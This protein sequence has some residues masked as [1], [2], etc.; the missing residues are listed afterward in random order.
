M[1]DI[2]SEPEVDKELI[3]EDSSKPEHVS[4]VSKAY[5]Q[6]RELIIDGR[7]APGTRIVEVD[8]ATRLGVSRTP[9]RDALRLLQQEGFVAA[10][11]P[12]GIKARLIVAPLTK[13]DAEEVYGIVGR[14]E[15]W[16]ARLSAQLPPA[17]RSE[18]AQKLRQLNNGLH[19]MAAT[20]PRDP[21]RTLSLDMEFH[22]SIVEASAGPRLLAIY[23]GIKPQ[24]ERYWRVYSHVQM[25]VDRSVDEHNQ[26]I[27]G[28]EEGNPD[29]AE[30]GAVMNWQHGWERV[31]EVIDKIG[32]R[33]SW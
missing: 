32:A 16:A 28:I 26:I 17:Q 13:E 31:C 22:R 19:E 7:L 11:S 23:N 30:H 12:G 2:S 14:L 29:V 21:Q 24:T 9:V 5:S 18:L 10:S 15:G 27:R 8:L 3:P 20:S 4:Q 25:H 6:L 33:G 1:K